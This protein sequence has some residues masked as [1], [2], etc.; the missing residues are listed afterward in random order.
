MIQALDGLVT[1]EY[2]FVHNRKLY[3]YIDDI[4]YLYV[5]IIYVY[6][7]YT[8]IYYIYIHFIYIYISNIYIY[9]YI[10]VR[11]CNISLFL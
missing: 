4:L 2:V 10:Y 6:I 3:I 5:Y 8:Y 11:I 7:I 1:I 9:I